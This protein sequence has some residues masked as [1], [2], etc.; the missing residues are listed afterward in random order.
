MLRLL[1]SAF[2]LSCTALFVPACLAPDAV[3]N[4][5][6][7]AASDVGNNLWTVSGT[8]HDVCTFD[9]V[10]NTPSCEYTNDP[11]PNTPETGCRSSQDP[12]DPNVL[13]ISGTDCRCDA[14]VTQNSVLLLHCPDDPKNG[15]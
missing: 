13:Y 10:D 6:L 12:N 3:P 9:V 8:C 5:C 1:C 11:I 14:G 2:L 7:I 4:A 15:P